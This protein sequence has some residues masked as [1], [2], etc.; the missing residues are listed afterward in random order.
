M[1]LLVAITLL[2]LL[3]LVLTGSLRFG[4]TAW[5]R[6]TDHTERGDQSLLVQHFLRRAIG[7]AYPYFLSTDLT[8]GDGDVDFVGAAQSLRFL[9]AA[10]IALGGRGRVRLEVSFDRSGGRSDLVAASVPELGDTTSVLQRKILLPDVEAVAFSYFGRRRSD[11]AAAWHDTWAA[12]PALPQLVRLNVRF[13]SGDI[14][15][16]RDFVIAP[17]ISAD[18]GCVHDPLTKRCRGR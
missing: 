14:R 7:G 12:E 10:P 13:S 18:V 3:S 9:A 1:E 17:R 5:A 15:L 2:S 11:R 6:G 4:L 16:W 8:R